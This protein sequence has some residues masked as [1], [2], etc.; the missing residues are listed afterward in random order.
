MML[1]L[2]AMIRLG[3]NEVKNK[4]IDMLSW[5]AR[6]HSLAVACTAH[7]SRIIITLRVYVVYDAH[8]PKVCV[9]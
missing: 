4:R 9:W 2:Y 3:L 5:S 6:T 7:I 8:F 1:Y